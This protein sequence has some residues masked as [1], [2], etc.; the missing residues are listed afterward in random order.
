MLHE[1]AGYVTLTNLG[2]IYREAARNVLHP[3]TGAEPSVEVALRASPQLEGR[4]ILTPRCAYSPLCSGVPAFGGVL[5]TF[6]NGPDPDREHRVDLD[7]RNYCCEL[8]AA[9]DLLRTAADG[10]H[11]LYD[12]EGTMHD[13]LADMARRSLDGE[14]M[15]GDRVSQSDIDSDIDRILESG[16]QA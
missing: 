4:V 10:M 5:V 3:T 1:R 2:Q 9:F 8:H 7:H 11:G 14:L 6:V 16:D 15:L 13:D 12:D